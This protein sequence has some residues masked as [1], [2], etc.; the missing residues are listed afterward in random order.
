VT[1]RHLVVTVDTEVDKS[2][3]WSVSD[4]PTF[5]SVT[6]ALPERM[7]P[8]CERF[9]VRTTFLLSPEVIEDRPSQKTLLSLGSS[10]EMGAHLHGDFIG[11]NRLLDA[12][13][14]GGARADAAQ[15]EYAPELEQ[16]KLRALT[17]LYVSVFGSRP[18]AFRAGRFS[19]SPST[20]TFLAELGYQVDS[21]VTPGLRWQFESAVADYRDWVAEGRTVRT[22]AGPIVELPV[23]IRP[24]SSLA[25]LFRAAPR[26]VQAVARRAT[27][28]RS[29]YH[30]LRPSWC[31]G[32]ELVQYALSSKERVLVLM[33]HNVELV[34]GASP[35]ARDNEGVD[36]I[37]GSLTELFAWC[38]E[39]GFRFS[40]MSEAAEL[41]S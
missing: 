39:N 23:S 10:H 6:Q 31:S 1:E 32:K 5:R 12:H 8:L 3:D 28:G 2:P 30:W 11:P 15:A 26:T 20:L 17:D 16:A 35:Y 36:R 34:A 33:M 27:A 21:S 18:R 38:S 25:P 29:D 40:T 24:G 9:G 7:V 22:P 41:V 4:P 14:A 19:I 37:L 13:N